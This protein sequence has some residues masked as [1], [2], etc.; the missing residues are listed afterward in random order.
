MSELAQVDGWADANAQAHAIRTGHTTAVGL[1]QTYLDRIGEFDDTLRSYVTVAGE[2]ALAEAAAAD[3]RVRDAAPGEPLPAFLGVTLSLKDVIDV[4]GLATTHS[5]KL[6]ADNVAD[7]DAPLVGRFREAGFIVLGKTNVPEFCTSMTS[8]E[9]NGVCRNPWDLNQTPGG[10]SGGAA[11]ALAAGLCAV[12]HGTDGAGSVRVPAAYCGLVGVKPT[13]GLSTAG[14]EEGA[15]YFGASEDGIMTRSVRDAAALLDV[16]AR[17]RWAPVGVAHHLDGLGVEPGPLRVAVSVEAPMGVTEDETAQATHEVSELLSSLGHAVQHATPPW[18]TILAVAD[19]PAW[20]PGLAALVELDDIESLEPRN[21]PLGRRLHELRVIDH[22]RWVER[23]RAA[24]VEFCRFWD[25]IDVLVTP[26]CGIPAPSVDFAPW[27][28]S[29]DEHLATFMSFP[30]FAQPFNLSGQPAISLPLAW[31]SSG[32][33]IGIQ[34]VGRH[35]EES[36]L[37]ALAAQLDQARPWAD[38][39]PSAI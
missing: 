25:D 19:G 26:T 31:H 20:V 8:S 17:S 37:L 18:G 6:L 1:V 14:P 3:Q 35:L 39:R 29:P 4:G 27:D 12:A 22:A 15:A 10:S 33:P 24:T 21:R 36:T 34:L 32:L 28:Q 13:R 23:A 38:R 9:L 11:A 2:Q 16:M 7:E 30:N 5:C